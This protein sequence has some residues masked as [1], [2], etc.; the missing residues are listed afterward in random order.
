MRQD[1]ST[2]EHKVGA[3][4]VGRENRFKSEILPQ[5][6]FGF[7]R[8]GDSAEVGI[9]KIWISMGNTELQ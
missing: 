5:N 2:L 8:G 9:K 7:G 1:Q 6:P 3:K 4:E